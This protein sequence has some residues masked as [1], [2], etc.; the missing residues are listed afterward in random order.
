M[1]RGG[2]NPSRR[3][4]ALRVRV[5]TRPRT[6]LP[7]V[8]LAVLTV[9]A[10]PAAGQNVVE[11]RTQPREHIVRRGDTLWGLA[12][13][14]LLNPLLWPR[15]FDANREVVEDPHWIYPDERL[16]IP[17]L[18]DT[19]A[20]P[21]SV[22][23]RPAAAA[24]TGGQPGARRTRSLFYQEPPPPPATTD[25]AGGA[26]GRMAQEQP[27]A[28]T[29]A[30][31]ASAPWLAD[32]ASLGTVGRLIHLA[33]PERR[34]DRLPSR[35]H[36][37]QLIYIGQLR[38]GLPAPGTEL[39]VAD[40]GDEVEGF[41]HAIVPLAL[42]E[43]VEHAGDAVVARVVKQYG[44]AQAG[45][46][47]IPAPATPELPR[48]EPSELAD[49]ARGQLIHFLD[50]DPLKGNPDQGFIDLGRAD[51]GPGDIVTVYL[52]ASVAGGTEL[53]TARIA[54]LKVIRTDETSST[55]RVLQ[56]ANTGL[57]DGMPVR[58]THRTP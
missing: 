37:Y 49:G 19:L 17:G 27:Y 43:V 42:V 50:D 30:E 58:V 1:V 56:V 21:I 41:G 25:G 44:D 9:P 26:T 12:R 54:R 39:L 11:T 32:S 3:D 7:L 2:G 55:V 22:M 6:L 31:Y 51:V 14:Y 10:A 8:I 33:D 48:G 16:R 40:V 47:V 24:A 20:V 57:A 23:E 38:A 45:N 13:T 36:P 4:T 28:V 53:Q 18:E 29:P 52:P 35:V 5:E 46:I 34:E 15:I